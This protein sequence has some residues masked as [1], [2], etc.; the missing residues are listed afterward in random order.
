MLAEFKVADDSRNCARKVWVQPASGGEASDCLIFLDGELYLDRVRAPSAI[1]ELRSAGRLT[2]TDCIYVSSIDAAARHTDYPCNRDFSSFLAGSLRN[3]IELSVNRHTLYALCGLSLS[4]LS[5]AFTAIR[6]PEAFIGAVCQSPS[7]WWNEEWLATSLDT[8][9]RTR[10]RFWISVGDRELDQGIAH[11]PSG[12][13]QSTSQLES[14]RR[15]ARKLESCVADL[16][17]SE[18]AGGHDPACWAT[19]L[20]QALAWLLPGASAPAAAPP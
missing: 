2:A 16:H 17:Y 15:L 8:Q 14:C 11:P 13:L 5:A 10:G 19:E 18:Y 3:W 4:G 7:A 9:V 20:P 6:H 12:L 1:E